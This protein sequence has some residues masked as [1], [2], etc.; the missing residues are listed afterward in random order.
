MRKKFADNIIFKEWFDAQPSE[1]RTSIK[2]I[3]IDKCDIKP[4]TFDNWLYGNSGIRMIYKKLINEL[5]GETVFDIN[6]V[7]HD[8]DLPKSV[9]NNL[10]S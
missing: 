1:L 8:H 9:P 7:P 2:N 10:Q 4:D 6:P 5:A 3:I